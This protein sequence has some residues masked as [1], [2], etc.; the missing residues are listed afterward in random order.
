VL[1]LHGPQGGESRRPREQTCPGAKAELTRSVG[2]PAP[3]KTENSE[4]DTRLL[5]S[6]AQT[7]PVWGQ[8]SRPAGGGHESEMIPAIQVGSGDAAGVMWKGGV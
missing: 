5:A 2:G 6:R 8:Y 7:C 3:G 1:C 4:W